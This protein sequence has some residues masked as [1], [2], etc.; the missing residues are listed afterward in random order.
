MFAS[1]SVIAFAAGLTAACATVESVDGA[2]YSMASA[3]FRDY[4]ESVFRRQN[5]ALSD[6]AFAL[7][8][9]DPGSADR[10][11]L[12]SAEEALLEACALLNEMAVRRRD[13]LQSGFGG[14][15]Q[16]GR[17]VPA[18]ERAVV[19]ASALL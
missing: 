16:A 8:S 9:T 11:R 12:E 14:R 4:A 1:R 5:L 10:R 19:Q 7:D 2:R 6:I 3:D 17:S 15:L 18:C 13:G